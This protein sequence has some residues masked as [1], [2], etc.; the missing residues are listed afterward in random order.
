ME[1]HSSV[2]G[3]QEFFSHTNPCDIEFKIYRLPNFNMLFQ[4]VLTKIFKG[5][6]FSKLTKLIDASARMSVRLFCSTC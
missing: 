3:W 2:S 4:L 1:N 6:L 5:E